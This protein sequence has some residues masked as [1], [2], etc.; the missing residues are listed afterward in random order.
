MFFGRKIL[1]DY[2]AG[3][4]AKSVSGAT[5]LNA[6]LFTFL[7]IADAHMDMFEVGIVR[8]ICIIYCSEGVRGIIDS[9]IA[10]IL[11]RCVSSCKLSRSLDQLKLDG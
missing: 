4:P 6:A 5:L 11:F 1:Y 2:S 10:F 3:Y 7:R 9:K 8:Q